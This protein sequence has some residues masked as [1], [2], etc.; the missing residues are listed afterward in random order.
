MVPRHYPPFLHPELSCTLR[1]RRRC[2]R[3]NKIYWEKYS[4]IFSGCR[5]V[6]ESDRPPACSPPPPPGE[7][8][9][10]HADPR[11]PCVITP[12]CS[13]GPQQAWVQT[14]P[15]S[16]MPCSQGPTVQKRDGRSPGPRASGGG[17]QPPTWTSGGS[18]RKRSASLGLDT[19]FW[20]AFR[21]RR[22]DPKR[23]SPTEQSLHTDNTTSTKKTQTR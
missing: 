8:P 4:M 23:C 14:C 22:D 6:R 7:R 16:S 5:R 20:S 15:A 10:S 19:A 3:L 17:R 1:R 12:R 13:P 18:L 11:G 9:Q 21:S 2:L